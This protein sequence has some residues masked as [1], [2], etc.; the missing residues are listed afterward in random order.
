M[1]QVGFI[2]MRLLWNLD[3]SLRGAKILRNGLWV[4]GD[5]GAPL[6]AATK[7]YSKRYAYL[8]SFQGQD[9]LCRGIYK[10]DMSHSLAPWFKHFGMGGEP[11]L[12]GASKA[13]MLVNG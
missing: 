11:Y 4:I 13:S 10:H 7:Y 9:E 2:I 6:V 5:G 3:W 8:L 12:L 1:Q